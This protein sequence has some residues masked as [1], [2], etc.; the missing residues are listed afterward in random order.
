MKPDVVMMFCHTPWRISPSQRSVSPSNG[1]VPFHS[2]WST[3]LPLDGHFLYSKGQ[4][5]ALVLE[6]CRYM[7]S[8]L[9]SQHYSVGR[10]IFNFARTGSCMMDPLSAFRS[11][12][13][14]S[15]S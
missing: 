14:T 2:Y 15:W 6:F 11:S 1:C 12:G 4:S 9:S 5:K 10:Q 13:Q 7:F 8:T 3:A